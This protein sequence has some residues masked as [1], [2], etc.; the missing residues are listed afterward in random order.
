M[1]GPDLHFTPRGLYIGG[2]WQQ[3]ADGG[4]LETINSSTGGRLGEVPLATEADI[5]RAVRAGR[6]AFESDWGRL[7]MRERAGY[8]DQRRDLVSGSVPHELHPPPTLRRGSQDQP[9]RPPFPI[10]RREGRCGVGYRQHGG[11]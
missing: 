9:V 5:A 4:R 10:L 8:R 11:G 1:I 3:L 7:P 6:K 2:Q